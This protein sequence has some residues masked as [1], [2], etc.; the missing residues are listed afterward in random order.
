ML[1]MASDRISS[2]ASFW[3]SAFRI[4][5]GKLTTD[6]GSGLMDTMSGGDLALGAPFTKR[7][8]WRR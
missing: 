2:L 6:A 1:A 8:E 3:I 5:V 4:G 7:L